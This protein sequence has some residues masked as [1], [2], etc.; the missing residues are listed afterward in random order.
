MAR[1]HRVSVTGSVLVCL[2]STQWNAMLFASE[3]IR[4]SN[5]GV[6]SATPVAAAQ[7]PA[8]ESVV[9]DAISIDERRVDPAYEASAPEAQSRP[10]LFTFDAALVTTNPPLGPVAPDKRAIFTLMFPEFTASAGQIYPGRPYRMRRD[11]SIAAIMI[12]AAAAIAGTALLVY[13][14]RPECSTD[15]SAGA[16]GYGTRVVG[17]SVLAGGIVGVFV[18][19]LTWR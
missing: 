4:A 17:T 18:G 13:A 7:T 9:I 5:D 15:Q 14:N 6:A 19:A 12:G 16:C 1:A 11:G 8:I 2:L 10:A 3:A